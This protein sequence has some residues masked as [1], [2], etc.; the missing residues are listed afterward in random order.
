[1]YRLLVRKVEKRDNCN[2]NS[3]EESKTTLYNVKPKYLKTREIR[4]NT[5]P[6]GLKIK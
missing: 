6:K 3:G 2:K 4:K 1:M 5:V